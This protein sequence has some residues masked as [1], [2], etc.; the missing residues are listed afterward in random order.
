MA[1][2]L[3]KVY[4]YDSTQSLVIDVSQCGATA[5]TMYVH[6]STGTGTI[7]NYIN[8]TTSCVF[9]YSGQ[10]AQIIN[11]GV[12]LATIT[13]TNGNKR[14]NVPS[15]Y[16]LSQNYPN[17]FNPVTVINFSIPKAGNVQLKV[18]DELGKE[19]AVLVNEY[20]K[21]GEYKVRFDGSNLSSGV[22]FYQIFTGDF[23]DT[24]KMILIK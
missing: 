22:Y 13:G 14:Y 10:D 24:K 7:R 8:G 18:F 21:P 15:I 12:Y 16:S 20:K 4:Y 2:N 6:Q 9:T 19:V 17:P 1:I 5:T 23:T 3:D 11:A